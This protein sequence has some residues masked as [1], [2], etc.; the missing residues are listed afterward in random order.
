MIRPS[1]EPG[2]LSDLDSVK[3]AIYGMPQALEQFAEYLESILMPITGPLSLPLPQRSVEI[4]SGVITVSGSE[5]VTVETQ[6][7]GALDDLDTI[8]GTAVGDIVILQILSDSKKVNLTTAGNI[9]GLSQFNS[10]LMQKTLDKA[11]LINSDGTNL[12][13]ISLYNN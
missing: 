9:T 1:W 13:A 12:H 2:P 7:G 8:N 3:Q 10:F 6:G 5:L 11:M 4:S